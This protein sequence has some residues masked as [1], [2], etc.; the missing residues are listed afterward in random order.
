MNDLVDR[1]LSPERLFQRLHRRRQAPLRH[2]DLTQVPS[3]Q[4][5]RRS[6]RP[7]GL[8]GGEAGRPAPAC[9]RARLGGRPLD[10]AR[11]RIRPG[12]RATVELNLRPARHGKHA[13]E[14]D[15]P[16]HRRSTTTDANGSCR[17]A[18]ASAL[19]GVARRA[20]RT[21]LVAW[22]SARPPPLGLVQFCWPS[23]PQP[24]PRRPSPRPARGRPGTLASLIA[25]INTAKR[26]AAADT[27]ALGPGCA[28]TLTSVDNYWYGPNGLPAIAATSRSRA[29]ARRS[30][31]RRR[32]PGSG[33]LLRRRR[34]R[35]SRHRGYVSPGAGQAD[36]ARR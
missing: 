17:G 10:A 2:G 15:A 1:L 5:G 8:P 36:A 28:Y 18:C 16:G 27:V 22:A 20:R 14:A 33:L 19:T 9:C 11:Y 35:Q 13:E 32:R 12:R 4:R 3:A 34:S 24:P 29:T 30:R 21:R 25:A 31:A 23:I 7:P 26:R 6:A